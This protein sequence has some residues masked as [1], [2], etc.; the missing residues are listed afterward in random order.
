MFKSYLKLTNYP[1]EV[2]LEM[3]I[4]YNKEILGKK[5][6]PPAGIETTTWELSTLSGK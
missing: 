5:S 2:K 6:E 1:S 4:K 3:D